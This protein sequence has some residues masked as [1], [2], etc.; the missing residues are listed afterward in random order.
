MPCNRKPGMGM[1]ADDP[2]EIVWKHY[3][4]LRVIDRGLDRQIRNT[5]SW[6]YFH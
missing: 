3:Q 6:G 4:R 1:G 2:P 5:A